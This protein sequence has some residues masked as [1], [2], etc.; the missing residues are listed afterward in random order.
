MILVSG[1]ARVVPLQDERRQGAPAV[2]LRAD[3]VD[4]PADEDAF[5]Q[6]LYDVGA[7]GVAGAVVKFDPGTRI[8]LGNSYYGYYGILIADGSAGAITFTSNAS[9]PAPGDWC[10]IYFSQY[11]N[12]GTLLD[13]VL[14]EH[15][16]NTLGA[17]IT[18]DSTS[19][20][21]I[22]NS[23]I[24]NNNGF[25]VKFSDGAYPQAFTNNTITGNT[26]YPIEIYG[27]FVRY[28]P[29]GNTITSG[30]WISSSCR[31]LFERWPSRPWS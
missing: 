1:I 21:A 26:S 5:S 10:G 24:S 7:L 13:N 8:V 3:L 18:F 30:T 6:V 9:T 29:S 17:G 25:G 4:V 15:A 20:P 12:S 14:V 31:D 2:L 22:Q 11:T 23:T 27:N 28:L 19:V 16:G